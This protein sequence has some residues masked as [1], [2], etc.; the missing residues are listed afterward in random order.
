M[1]EALNLAM[2]YLEDRIDRAAQLQ[3]QGNWIEAS[4]LLQEAEALA[5]SIDN[6]ED[7]LTMHLLSEMI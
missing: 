3:A 5:Q 2:G 1:H 7:I 6:E 4:I